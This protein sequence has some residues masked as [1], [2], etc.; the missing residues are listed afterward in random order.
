M[1]LKQKN[2]I[3]KSPVWPIAG[4]DFRRFGRLLLHKLKH[5]LVCVDFVTRVEK[6]GDGVLGPEITLFGLLN[7]FRYDFRPRFV[8]FGNRF[9]WVFGRFYKVVPLFS[10]INQPKFDFSKTWKIDVNQVYKAWEVQKTSFQ[11]LKR[12]LHTFPPRSQSQRRLKPLSSVDII[13]S[14]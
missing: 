10:V 9:F 7:H 13:S 5:W 11:A 3:F 14:F 4:L 2:T 1:P 6:C 12:H 8:F